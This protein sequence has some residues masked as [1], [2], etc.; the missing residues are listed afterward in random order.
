[1]NVHRPNETQDHRS[2]EQEMRRAKTSRTTR[3]SRCN[4]AC[5]GL[6]DRCPLRVNELPFTVLPNKDAGPAALLIYRSVLI[7]SFGRGAIGHNGGVPVN[8]DFN[9]VRYQRVKIHTAGLT[10]LQVL[11]PVL[12]VSVRAVMAVIFV[13]DPLQKSHVRFHDSR[14]EVLDKLRQLPLVVG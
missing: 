8:A 12:D 3:W 6:L 7:F 10:I 14:I 4:Y 11:S 13:Q 1:A 2:R 5:S 9:I